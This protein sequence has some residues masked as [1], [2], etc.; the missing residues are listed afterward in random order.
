MGPKFPDSAGPSPCTCAADNLRSAA[1]SLALGSQLSAA[2]APAASALSNGVEGVLNTPDSM[3]ALENSP[4]A[5]GELI[6]S[7]TAAP[8][9]DWPA[10]VTLR[11][12]PPKALMFVCTHL[13]AASTSMRP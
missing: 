8:P 7:Y 13:S 5:S 9:A 6:R 12:S 3:M 4:S 1:A 2:A 10:S 11:G